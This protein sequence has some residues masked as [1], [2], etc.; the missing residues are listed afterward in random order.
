MLESLRFGL[1]ERDPWVLSSAVVVLIVVSAIAAYVPAL[2][3]S[4]VDPVIALRS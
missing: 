4:R 3:A 2:R 1:E